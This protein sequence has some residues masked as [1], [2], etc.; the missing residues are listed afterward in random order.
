MTKAEFKAKVIKDTHLTEELFDD[1]Y[2]IV[3]ED[4]DWV[5]KSNMSLMLEKK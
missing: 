3:K 5:A 1:S 2:T 4:G